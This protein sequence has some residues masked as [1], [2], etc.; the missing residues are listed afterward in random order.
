MKIIDQLQEDKNGLSCE[1]FPPKEGGQLANA[2]DIVRTISQQGVDFISV[3]Y[4]AG[5]TST[6]KTVAI[7]EAA[8][9]CGV[10]AM[11]HLTCVNAEDA[12]IEAMLDQLQAAGVQNVLA[13]R[14]DLP[15]GMELTYEKYQHASDLAKKI[16][17]YGDFCV[18]GAC[19]PEGHPES[20]GLND[21]IEKLKIK[22]DSGV[23]FLVT[24]MFFDNNLIYNYMYR[25]LARGVT[26]PVIPGIMPVI[27]ASQIT[28]ICKLSGTKLPP[29]FR[30]II[31]K[32]AHDPEA[33]KQAGINYAT[34]QVLDLLANGFKDVH[35]YTMNK[36][37]IIGGIL[38]N[39]SHIV[40]TQAR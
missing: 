18:G 23:D 3:T 5:G 6:G 30:S 13:L 35:I 21:D 12:A 24:Q 38:Q 36:P 39:L 33:M 4:G 1:L 22:V 29:H 17:S 37:E 34:T 10:P 2:L 16:K 27:N 15:P 19:Y 26:V 32:F 11:A 40:G 25:L 9:K 7:A 20:I 14:G 31:E 28:R 8:E